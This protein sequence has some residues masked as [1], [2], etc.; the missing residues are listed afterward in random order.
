MT[1]PNRRLS[2]RRAAA[3]LL[4]FVIVLV[5]AGI[6]AAFL[7][8]SLARHRS[9]EAG[10]RSDRA[11]FLAEAGISAALEDLRRGGQ[12]TL[13]SADQ[14]ILLGEGAYHTSAE[15]VEPNVVSIRAVGV[16]GRQERTIV[17]VARRSVF[18]PFGFS[19]FGDEAVVLDSNATSDSYDSRLGPHDDQ[20]SGNFR[21][22]AY[23]G[24]EGD[25]GS[26]GPITLASNGKVFGSAIPGP[27]HS[28]DLLSNN[29]HVSGS[30]AP[31]EVTVEMPAIALPLSYTDWTSGSLPADAVLDGGQVA[32]LG[33]GNLHL[34]SLFLN[35]T[36]EL[37]VRG[38]A[39][40]VLDAF[41]ARSNTRLEIDAASGP[42]EIYVLGRFVVDSNV[43]INNQG[44]NPADLRLFLDADN[45]ADPS[46]EV[47]LN[48][49]SAIHGVLY[50]PRARL[51]VDSNVQV[52]GSLVGRR[53]EVNSAAAFHYDVG[54]RDL[55]IA[56]PDEFE[57][58]SWQNR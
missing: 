54:L 2:D 49:N 11:F 50:A 37:T 15:A 1:R 41:E 46:I 48:S 18:R 3:L 26:N 57:L 6:A 17:A 22:S 5:A 32:T 38:P 14:P 25:V 29:N 55:E 8:P 16:S 20:V 7:M 51:V 53:I 35:S 33:P 19:L 39:I 34:T 13:G 36:A 56:R 28:V 23:A 24:Q 47:A 27:G 42:V 43:E 58:I 45:V 12:G 30:T 21:G 44:G 31:A 10:I 40:L 9:S 4:T 52:H